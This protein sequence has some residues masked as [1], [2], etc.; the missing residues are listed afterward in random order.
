M[1]AL[2][3]NL[4]VYAHRSAVAEHRAAQDAIT[5]AGRHRDGWGLS[6]AVVFEFWCVVTHPAASG[7][8]STPAE[9]ATFV[10]ALETAGAQVWLPGIGFGTRL[11]QLAATQSVVGPRIFDLQI[12]LTAFEGG[13]T[14]LWTADRRFVSIPGLPVVCPLEG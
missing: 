3:T 1:I 13:A 10:A 12:A 6:L 7:R 11:M 4:L 5:R 2:D 8:P 14:E 9:A